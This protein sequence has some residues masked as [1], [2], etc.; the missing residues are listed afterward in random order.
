MYDKNSF[1]NKLQNNR[2]VVKIQSLFSFDHT[3][4]S[5]A[6]HPQPQKETFSFLL[7][8]FLDTI[9]HIYLCSIEPN[10]GYPRET[11]MVMRS[12]ERTEA[13]LGQ[14]LLVLCRTGILPIFF[15]P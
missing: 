15:P 14:K 3:L 7:N 10:D 2:S 8:G 1:P 12:G 11:I 4:V 6:F 9:C 13:S 5:T